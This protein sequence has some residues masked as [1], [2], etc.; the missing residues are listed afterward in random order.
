MKR[1]PYSPNSAIGLKA[2]WATISPEERSAR[3]RKAALAR[4]AQMTL[5]QKKKHSELMIAAKGIIRS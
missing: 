5:R 2:Y 4:S 1:L 3:A